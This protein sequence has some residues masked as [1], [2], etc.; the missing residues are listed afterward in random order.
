MQRYLRA[1]WR[2]ISK[3]LSKR[4]DKIEGRVMNLIEQEKI[5]ATIKALQEHLKECKKLDMQR[6]DL[7]YIKD[8]IAMW[9][10]KLKEEGE[11]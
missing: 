3:M 7:K 5:K 9:E 4:L 1:Y 11:Q 2:L 8:E 6:E 10:K